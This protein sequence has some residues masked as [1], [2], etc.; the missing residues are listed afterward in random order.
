MRSFYFLNYD[1]IRKDFRTLS[2][3]SESFNVPR[4]NILYFS[5]WNK[6]RIKR[7]K[8]PYKYFVEK[9]YRGGV[10]FFGFDEDFYVGK[11]C[12]KSDDYRDLVCCK[13]CFISLNFIKKI[14]KTFLKFR[15]V[16]EVKY[17]TLEDGVVNAIC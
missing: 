15:I 17:L 1:E 7:H 5:S 11:N 6:K 9:K 13:T 3:F 14:P 12:W 4:T 8:I 16:R 2:C 10:G